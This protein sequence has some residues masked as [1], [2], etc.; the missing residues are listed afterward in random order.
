M[1]ENVKAGG[2]VETGN[3]KHPHHQAEPMAFDGEGGQRRCTDD[4][5]ERAQA[6]DIAPRRPAD[7]I[8]DQQRADERGHAHHGEQQRHLLG[9]LQQVI[10]LHRH[11]GGDQRSGERLDRK[12]PANAMA[13]GLGAA[14]SQTGLRTEK[15]MGA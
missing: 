1:V 11:D 5:A 8:G 9:R 14:N 4:E 3:A 6:V 15:A 7:E 2:D 12:Q 13:V 10:G